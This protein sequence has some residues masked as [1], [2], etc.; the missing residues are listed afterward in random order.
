MTKKNSSLQ[1]G[2][3]LVW[4]IVIIAGLWVLWYFTGG[5]QRPETQGGPFLDPE[6]GGSY[7]IGGQ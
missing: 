7:G 1:K 5:P 4:L 3:A 6:T 2:N